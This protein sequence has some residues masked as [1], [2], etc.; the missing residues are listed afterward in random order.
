MRFSLA[1]V[2]STRSRLPA[3]VAGTVLLGGGSLVAGSAPASAANGPEIQAADPAV[4]DLLRSDDSLGVTTDGGLMWADDELVDPDRS[5][6]TTKAAKSAA[7]DALSADDV[8]SL[9]SN[10]GAGKLIFLDVDGWTIPE[11]SGY[12]DLDEI[13]GS[14][15][16]PWDPA[17]DGPAFSATELVQI[18]QAWAML[19]E[20]FAPFEVDVT[21]EDP[22][23]AGLVRADV[24][25]THYGVRLVATPDED[26]WVRL[27]RNNG[28]SAADF[29]HVGRSQTVLVFPDH[30]DPWRPHDIANIGAHE[31]G[32]SLG[33]GH[34]TATF[35][36]NGNTFQDNFSGRNRDYWAPIGNW[37][38]IMGGLGVELA[39]WDR[40]EFPGAENHQDDL[41]IIGRALGVRGDEAATSVASAA[42]LPDSGAFI[43]SQ[44]DVDSWRLGTCTAG[45]TVRVAPTSAAPSLDVEASLVRQV[46]S[47]VIETVN[48]PAYFDWGTDLDYPETSPSALKGLGATLTVEEPGTGYVLQV[49]GGG[50]GTWADDGYESYGSLGQYTLEVEGCDGA[51]TPGAPGRPTDLT[52]DPSAS[53]AS[54]ELTWNAPSDGGAVEEYVVAVGAEELTT[55][56]TSIDVNGL[57]FGTDYVFQVSAVN[58]Q[59]SSP[60]ARAAATTPAGLPGV[61]GALTAQIQNGQH[62]YL[63]WDRAVPHGSP[64]TAYRVYREDSGGQTLVD[65]IASDGSLIHYSA[66]Q[67]DGTVT[68]SVV[69]VNATGEGEA[70]TS[71]PLSFGAVAPVA[72]TGVTAEAHDGSATVTWSPSLSSPAPESYTVTSDPGAVTVDVGGGVTQAEVSGLQDGDAYTFTVTATNPSGEGTSEPSEP[73]VIGGAPITTDDVPGHVVNEPV[74]VTL[75]ATDASGGPLETR[76]TIGTESTPAADPR[77][78]GGTAYDAADK[79]ELGDGEYLRYSST[80]PSGNTEE[81]QDSTVAQVAAAI[82]PPVLTGAVN[83]VGHTVQVVP[84]AA[85]PATADLSYQWHR[86]ALPG[87]DWEDIPG[88]DGTS[89]VLTAADSGHQVSLT[90]TAEADGHRPASST[91]LPSAVVVGVTDAATAGFGDT[92]SDR[93]GTEPTSDNNSGTGP[94]DVAVDEAGFVYVPNQGNR[95]LQKFSATGELVETWPAPPAGG[96]HTYL[97]AV[98]AGGPDGHVYAVDTNNHRVLEYDAY[99]TLVRRMAVPLGADMLLQRQ[100]GGITVDDEGNIY[101][102]EFPFGLVHKLGPDGTVL[103]MWGSEGSGAEQLSHPKGMAVRDGK[104]YVADSGNGRVQVLDAGTGQ[105]LSSWNAAA[106]GGK[107]FVS[108]T[109]IAFDDAGNVYVMESGYRVQ[110]FDATRSF[111]EELANWDGFSATARTW[112][113][114]D[115]G[116][117]DQVYVAQNYPVEEVV[118]V[119]HDPVRFV[120][121]A[122]TGVAVTGRYKKATVDWTAPASANGRPVTGYTVSA[123]D[124]NSGA[125]VASAQVAADQRT[126]TV[127]GLGNGT[128]YRFTVKATNAAGDSAASATTNGIT[129]V[130]P[131]APTLTTQAGDQSATITWTAPDPADTIPG[132]ITYQ[133]ESAGGLGTVTITGDSS[134][135]VSGLVNGGN[136]SFRVKGTNASGDSVTSAWSDVTPFGKPGAPTGVQ[137]SPGNQKATVTWTAPSHNGRPITGYTVTASPGGATVTT[138][139]LTATVNGLTNGTE[140]TFTVR[141]TNEAGDSVESAAATAT[142]VEG[143]PEP[144]PL[145]TVSGSGFSSRTPKVG[146][147]VHAVAGT[148]TPSDTSL[149]YE[150]RVGARV[151]STSTSYTPQPA[152]VGT[153]LVL[154]IY[155]SRAGYTSDSVTMV[156]GAVAKGAI[157]P[158]GKLALS[159][160]YAVGK[161]VKVVSDPWPPNT[162]VTYQWFANG[163][164]IKGATKAKLKLKKP[165]A[166]KKITVMVTA[167]APGHND[168]IRTLA[169]EK[170]KAVK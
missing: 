43:T 162:K 44:S 120:P 57:E 73:V 21:T 125:V 102:S 76:Y 17:G 28:V 145:V 68:F 38:P 124:F 169:G 163:K 137:A 121:D 22:G 164:A 115:L 139:G 52:A 24:A 122:P 93:F 13:A 160:K 167:R 8:F 84:P 153:N 119:G 71:G 105:F 154:T 6:S 132:P 5:A 142:P 107:Q 146:V 34:D 49:R 101:V 79:P 19:A 81:P 104:L 112:R 116:A 10:P 141:A 78:P 9:H 51:T 39:H 56:D 159:G 111:V 158:P 95:R 151:V 15:A 110:K 40:G 128:I 25:D 2:S 11:D 58:D 66:A 14:T 33:L 152:D 98:D 126:A 87:S 32:H 45:A 70:A 161:T 131:A 48:P 150:W 67:P 63:T 85:V 143:P 77:D 109:D 157:T 75:D 148:W 136:Y 42:D 69:A 47:T 82:E 61:P 31:V 89:Y 83:Q 41:A 86:R 64:I 26:V 62:A 7:R 92:V 4:R 90:V 55:A 36:V 168:L 59:G 37:S 114:F 100:A 97:A 123:L 18:E 12:S 138:T 16:G 74:E 170:V 165:Q 133:V 20:R 80:D 46:D 53:E 113:G 3:L 149:T 1:H 94:G 144:D 60:A 106:S 147:P 23:E 156:S 117:N 108:P 29:E 72:P 50:N 30:G 27:G 96:Y 166:K 103:A 99:G 134:A 35:T 54:V 135:T 155:G 140:Y 65:T 118:M 129:L 130:G 88:A 91:S 127:T